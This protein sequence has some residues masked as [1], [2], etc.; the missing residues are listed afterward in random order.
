[1][2]ALAGEVVHQRRGLAGEVAPALRGGGH[3]RGSGDALT[4]AEPLV[5]AEEERAV[6]YER[7]ARGGAELI[8]LQ[9]FDLLGEEVPRVEKVVP[10][11]LVYGTVELVAAGPRDHAGHGPARAAVLGRRGVRQDAELGDGIDGR[12]QRVTAV[13]AVHVARAVQ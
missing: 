8:L 7:S 12:L 10:Q 5:P 9:G 11:E 6:P 2:R 4:V 13:H 3:G 1:M